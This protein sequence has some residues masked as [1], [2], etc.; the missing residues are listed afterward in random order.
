MERLVKDNW[1]LTRAVRRLCSPPLTL[2]HLQHHIHDVLVTGSSA[3]RA[4]DTIQ[5]EA[6]TDKA[7][8]G[9]QPGPSGFHLRSAF[10]GP[11]HTHSLDLGPV[12]EK[13]GHRNSPALSNMPHPQQ[14]AF[15]VESPTPE[16]HS[17]PHP[18][19][20][21][22]LARLDLPPVLGARE[23]RDSPALLGHQH[24]R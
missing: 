15:P 3:L 19:S 11:C 24:L 12:S 7:Q 17:P 9:L 14:D 8:P 4:E 6:L 22:V 16:V 18:V 5:E 23:A 10:L 20:P 13:P 1:V 21:V 2:N